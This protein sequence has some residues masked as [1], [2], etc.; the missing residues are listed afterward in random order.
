[1]PFDSSPHPPG[2]HQRSA[3][4]AVGA[5]AEDAIERLATQLSAILVSVP[6]AIARLRLR[7]RAGYA[8]L[9]W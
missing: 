5:L 7:S 2:T 8:I 1:M 6:A 9:C 4:H 3:C